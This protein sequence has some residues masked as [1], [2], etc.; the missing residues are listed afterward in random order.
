MSRGTT[1]D[2]VD[3]AMQHSPGQNHTKANTSVPCKQYLPE[4]N[5]LL[6]PLVMQFSVVLQV[7]TLSKELLNISVPCNQYLT[8][9]NALLQPLVM[10]F[11]VVLQVCTLYWVAYAKYIIICP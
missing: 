9:T 3:V 7:C 8:E 5:A 11:S 1:V 4:T 10:Q 6:Q 2:D